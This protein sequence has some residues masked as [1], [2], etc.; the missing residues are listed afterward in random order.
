MGAAGEAL[1]KPA[2]PQPVYCDECGTQVGLAQE[3]G[4]FIIFGRHHG[5]RHET[6]VERP[7]KT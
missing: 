5:Q 4:S 1:N 3:G 6:F 7:P 2:A